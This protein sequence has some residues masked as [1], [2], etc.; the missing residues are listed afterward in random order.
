MS[1]SLRICS[2]AHLLGDWQKNTISTVQEP[3]HDRSAIHARPTHT[4]YCADGGQQ[5]AYHSHGASA[6]S[7][8]AQLNSMMQSVKVP[9]LYLLQYHGDMTKKDA[10][11][12]QYPVLCSVSVEYI[13]LIERRVQVVVQPDRYNPPAQDEA[14]RHAESHD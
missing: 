9:C 1:R 2:F 4:I 3:Q 7:N 13:M 8:L 5:P 11:R 12:S 10:P 14:W 6:G